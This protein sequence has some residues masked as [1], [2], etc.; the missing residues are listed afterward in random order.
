M[1]ASVLYPHE[2]WGKYTQL[3]GLQYTYDYMYNMEKDVAEAD[4][5]LEAM[6]KN[7][8]DM[9]DCGNTM[10]VVDGSGSMTCSYVGVKPINVS[11]SL[12]VYFAE[13]CEGEFKNILMEFSHCPQLI[14]LNGCDTLRDKIV[15]MNKYTDCTNTDIES[16]F[17]LILQT[18]IDGGMKQSDLPERLLIVSD[19]EFDSA[20]NATTYKYGMKALFDELA[21][22]YAKYGFKMPK[23][24]FWNVCSRTNTIPLTENEMGVIL[25][26]GFSVNVLSMVMSGQTDPWLALKEKLDEDRYSCISDILKTVR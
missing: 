14:D 2:V 17:M 1:H 10:V 15:E 25:V 12:G 5:A 13:R 20:T 9:G 26:S 21:D 3:P 4:V 19:M 6:W 16:V 7:L 23:L 22:R 11:R 8:A 24:V 18:A